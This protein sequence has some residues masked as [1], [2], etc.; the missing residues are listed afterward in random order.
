MDRPRLLVVTERYWPDGSG[1]ELATHLILD[2]LRERF[3]I[4]VLTGTA[5]PARLPGV[6]YVYELLLSRRKKVALWPNCMRL[7]K[8]ARFLELLRENDIVYV[9]RF[10][11]PVIP[12]AKRL[13]KRVVVHLHDYAPVSYTAVILAPYEEHKHRISHDDVVLECAKGPA[14]C[15]GAVA[16]W[17]LP[18]LARRWL[19]QADRIICVSRR[20][21]EIIADLAPELGGKIEVVYNP[22]PPDLA[23]A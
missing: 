17:W 4:T 11:Y 5:R 6:R 14:H 21:A 15:A 23:T 1:G 13:G 18:R 16:L 8:S 19:S 20:H 22:P 9:P 2:V 10:A 7:A 3:N 12:A